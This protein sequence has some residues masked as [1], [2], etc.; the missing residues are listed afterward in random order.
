[1]LRLRFVEGMQI[2]DIA[3]T[4]HLPVRPLYRRIE[5]LLADLRKAL[6]ERGVR[7]KDLGWGAGAEGDIAPQELPDPAGKSRPTTVSERDD[8]GEE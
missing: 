7:A 4:L 8:E 3:R 6:A 2:A 1:M 5:R